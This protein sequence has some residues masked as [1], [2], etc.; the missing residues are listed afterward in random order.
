MRYPSSTT[1]LSRNKHH[2]IFFQIG[3]RAF[4]LRIPSSNAKIVQ[5]FPPDLLKLIATNK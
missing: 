2:L 1:F 5:E 3:T 4:E